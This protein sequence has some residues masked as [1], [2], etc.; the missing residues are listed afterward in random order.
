MRLFTKFVIICNICF[1][2]AAILRVIEMPLHSNASKDNIIPLPAVEATIVILGLIVAIIL[3]TIFVT[4][5]FVK[6]VQKKPILIH[7]YYKWFNILLLPIQ[8]WHTFILKK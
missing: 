1:V 8:F 6:A 3:N 2:I 4:I 5:L 7:K